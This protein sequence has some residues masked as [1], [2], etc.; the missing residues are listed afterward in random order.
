MKKIVVVGSLDSGSKND[1]HIIVEALGAKGL[2]VQLVE[3]EEL[4]F[5]VA[6]NDVSIRCGGKEMS[7]IAPELVIAV[8]WYRS[9]KESGYRDVALAMAAYLEHHG[10]K[11]WNS[12]MLQQRS[13]AKLS[14]LVKLAL[15]GI[16]VTPTRFSLRGKHVVPSDSD[17]Y[18]VVIK[19]SAASRGR[20][21]Y[22]VE[23]V[24]I[25]LEL[26]NDAPN[27]MLVQPFMQND[28]DIR[29]ILVNG[30]A[31]LVLKRQR[32]EGPGS[33]MNNTSQG[34]TAEWLDL[35]S[36]DSNILT[37]S[38]KIGKVMNREMAGIDLIPDD[39][40]EFGYSCLEVNAL[41]QLTSGFDTE[42]KLSAFAEVIKQA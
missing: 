37:I 4:V 14:C 3:W 34:G 5:D 27:G 9:G 11:F 19:A 2:D 32:Q 29:V 26:L 30:S 41:P 31:A 42:T 39:N 33:H 21:N 25:A 35:E 15:A 1:P 16:D 28:H 8:G 38:C 6:K 40:A 18:P 17:A 13:G 10:I 22:L 12:E 20:S 23:N 36:V 7:E 24:D